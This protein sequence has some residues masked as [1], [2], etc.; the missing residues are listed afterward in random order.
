MWRERD[1]P[2]D[3]MPSEAVAKL[4]SE[5]RSEILADKSRLNILGSV[6]VQSR[7]RDRVGSCRTE[8]ETAGA[9]G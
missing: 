9:F 8:T 4:A 1:V 6:H 7:V 2:P 5:P 3:I